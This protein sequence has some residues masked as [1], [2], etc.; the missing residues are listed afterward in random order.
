MMINIPE[1]RISPNAIPVITVQ[2]EYGQI[3]GYSSGAYFEGRW[4]VRDGEGS[5][6]DHSAF[7]GVL[8]DRWP[9]VR[10][11]DEHRHD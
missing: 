7:L 11:I 3:P 2:R 6:E 4:V 1:L 10:V 5:Y 9:G 8:K